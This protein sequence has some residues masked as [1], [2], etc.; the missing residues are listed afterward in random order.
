MPRLLLE[1]ISLEDDFT[2]ES[3]VNDY[4]DLIIKSE[5][6]ESELD[7]N[8]L[9]LNSGM[10]TANGLATLSDLTEHVTCE[11]MSFASDLLESM[12]AQV[13]YEIPTDDH[14]DLLE[15]TE[16]FFIDV[17]DALGRTITRVLDN[18]SNFYLSIKTRQYRL[19]SMAKK[20]RKSIDNV[21]EGNVKGKWISGGNVSD[22]FMGP[23]DAVAK[24]QAFADLRVASNGLINTLRN[25]IKADNIDHMY[26]QYRDALNNFSNL[27]R[28]YNEDEK[29]LIKAHADLTNEGVIQ[30]SIP[31]RGNT[32][33]R[34][35]VLDLA[36]GTINN[37]IMQEAKGLLVGKGMAEL[38]KLFDTT[39]VGKYLTNKVFKKAFKLAVPK[40]VRG[41]LSVS[42]FFRFGNRAMVRGLPARLGISLGTAMTPIYW[43]GTILLWDF[44][45]HATRTAKVFV[46]QRDM[47]P[48][49]IEQCRKILIAVEQMD[50]NRMSLSSLAK[51]MQGIQK[52]LQRSLNNSK[53]DISERT[54]AT[55]LFSTLMQAT[56]Y[57]RAI[58]SEGIYEADAATAYALKSIKVHIKN[59]ASADDFTDH[60][61]LE[62]K[63]YLEDIDELITCL[64]ASDGN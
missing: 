47:R 36:M 49:S 41:K 39:A 64:T 61:T 21:H 7:F 5:L 52:R 19:A 31:G 42:T 8:L 25:L 55:A 10:Q 63:K 37:K 11:D 15:T 51:S 48:L 44:V 3:F 9:Q 27:D 6:A 53:I 38:G 32:S 34:F 60:L 56:A 45:T 24:T 50:D 1:D 17:I 59:P 28:K 58:Y 23:P 33:H 29:K 46:S 13:G 57:L 16:G 14:T 4:K 12:A 20:L 22:W 30:I 2:I 54:V 35:V 26:E 18:W 40:A 43:M 62:T